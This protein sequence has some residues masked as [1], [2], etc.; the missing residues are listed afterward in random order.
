[1]F[2]KEGFKDFSNHRCKIML[3]AFLAFYIKDICL[4]LAYIERML[5]FVKK[6]KKELV[7]EMDNACLLSKTK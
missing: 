4:Y 2:V 1:M 3:P 5:T 6:E 7:S